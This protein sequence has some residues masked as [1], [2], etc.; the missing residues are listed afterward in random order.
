MLNITTNK[1]LKMLNR[2]MFFRN[3][4]G[5]DDPIGAVVIP[6][7]RISS[8]GEGSDDAGSIF[9]NVDLIFLF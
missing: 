4:I 6:M 3:R 7:S 9:T 2:E 1:G 8:T 5:S